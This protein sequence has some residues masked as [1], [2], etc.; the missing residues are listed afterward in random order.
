[1][2]VCPKPNGWVSLYKEED[3][4]RQTHG[5]GHVETG[6]G[7]RVL[8]SQEKPRICQ[9]PPAA[10][11]TPGAIASSDAPRRHRPSDT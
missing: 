2:R 9:K 4:Q 11:E 6:A 7:D 10:G 1:M 5:R 3:T 8:L